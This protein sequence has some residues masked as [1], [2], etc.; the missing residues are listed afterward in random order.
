MKKTKNEIL[1]LIDS[2][3]KDGDDLKKT[4]VKRP[5]YSKT[6]Y[7]NMPLEIVGHF[8]DVDCNGWLN[9]T[10]RILILT[11]ILKDHIG[12]WTV[13]EKPHIQKRSVI[14]V[15]ILLAALRAIR[16]AVNSD[17][18]ITVDKL[19]LS[20]VFGDFIEQAWHLNDN[21]YSLNA[22]M[23]GRVILE[24][25]LRKLC[26]DKGVPTGVKPT[27]QTFINALSFDTIKKK[28][29][30]AL[31]AMG[32]HCTHNKYPPHTKKE[33]AKFLTRLGEFIND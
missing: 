7:S 25:H 26:D 12:Y 18:L 33:I 21:G 5:K 14:V 4:T 2:L 6:R 8:E 23:L 10:Q 3:I 11:T 28:E 9:W 22:G 15:D 19:I 20:E 30:E 32:N 27:I 17:M 29:A 16:E 1:D 13:L 31:A 24:T